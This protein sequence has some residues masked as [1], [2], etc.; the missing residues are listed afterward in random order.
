M[1]S[2]FG[3]DKMYREWLELKR[4]IPPVIGVMGRKFFVD[5]FAKQGWDD[6]GLQ[7]WEQRKDKTNTRAIL[8]GKSGGTKSGAH[9]HLRQAVRDSLQSSSW[10]AID[11]VVKGVP[12]AQIHNEG[13][14]GL[15]FG[16]YPFKMPQ[17]QFMGASGTLM[18]KITERIHLEMAKIGFK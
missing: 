10:E 17:R 8:V 14:E 3:I 15:A 11:Y 6:N 12:Y 18:N 16:K 1:S 7:S 4:T 2:A 5:S 13:G 9:I